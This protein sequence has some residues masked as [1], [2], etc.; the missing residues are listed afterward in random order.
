MHGGDD[1]HGEWCE[2]N[3]VASVDGI[4]SFLFVSPDTHATQTQHACTQ[5]RKHEHSAR[6]H[7]HTHPL[8]RAH[9]LL[10]IHTHHFL[11]DASI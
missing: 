9:T 8:A 10:K 7:T 2:G 1:K 6:A 4:S 5:A 11:C 3:I